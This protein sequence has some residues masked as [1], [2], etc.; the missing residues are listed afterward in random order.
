MVVNHHVTISDNHD[1]SRILITK[2]LFELILG[3][4][5][6]FQY[7]DINGGEIKSPVSVSVIVPERA[8][9]IFILI[10]HLPFV[11]LH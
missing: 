4:I 7:L 1:S 2:M 11:L 8:V 5:T 9:F 3:V 6:R 10:I